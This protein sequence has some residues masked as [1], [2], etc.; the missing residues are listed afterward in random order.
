MVWE[1]AGWGYVPF[2]SFNCLSL[3][4]IRVEYFNKNWSS[5]YRIGRLILNFQIIAISS[6]YELISLHP[7][8]CFFVS[9]VFAFYMMD[10]FS[11]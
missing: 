10:I 11:T 1:R 9:P 7:D 4:Q 2:F 3:A 8:L 6:N 5:I